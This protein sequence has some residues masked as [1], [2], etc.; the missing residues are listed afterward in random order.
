MTSTSEKTIFDFLNT[1]IESGDWIFDKFSKLPNAVTGKGEK[2]LQRYV[3]IP[4]ARKDRIVLVAHVDTVWD[5]EYSNTLYESGNVGFKNGAFYS[6]SSGCG[7]GADDRAGCAMLWELRD[8]GHSILLLDGEEHG[9]IGA[10]FLKES[11][12]KLFRELNRHCF[13]AELDW[14]GTD[15]CLYNQVDNTEKFKRYIEKNIGFYDSKEKGGCDLQ[16]LCKK[17][18]GV[19]LGVG[20]YGYHTDKEI[21]IL[22]EWENT[23]TK[24]IEFLRKPQVKFRSKYFARYVRFLKYCVK[25]IIKLS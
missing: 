9:K 5:R 11:N 6:L 15:C 14:K 24:L 16:V 25:K 2:P 19:N 12:K 1:S 18:C 10:K 23:L 22:S 7:I 21:L 3:Y 4:G 8:S 20:Y 17:I 13:M